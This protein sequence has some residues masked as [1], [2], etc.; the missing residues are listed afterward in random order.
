MTTRPLSTASLSL[1]ARDMSEIRNVVA[2]KVPAGQVDDAVSEAYLRIVSAAPGSPMSGILPMLTGPDRGQA[3]R[4]FANVARRIVADERRRESIVAAA[5][6]ADG[7]VSRPDRDGAF[8][9]VS[10]IHNSETARK[11]LRNRTGGTRTVTEQTIGGSDHNARGVVRILREQSLETMLARTMRTHA[12]FTTDDR[13]DDKFA[14]RCQSAYLLTAPTPILSGKIAAE[15][16]A[17]IAAKGETLGRLLYDACD[18]TTERSRASV[19][20]ATARTPERSVIRWT[21]ILRTLNL[22]TGVVYVRSLKAHAQALATASMRTD[23]RYNGA[24]VGTSL[25]FPG[26]TV[27]PKR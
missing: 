12:A 9:T 5:Y 10:D 15:V 14:D 3:L 2:A 4:R 27:A 11:S 26:R 16:H 25:P 8:R 23:I 17:A 7:P 6:A 20:D 18:V 13:S 21:D 19:V 22:P 1:T 24:S